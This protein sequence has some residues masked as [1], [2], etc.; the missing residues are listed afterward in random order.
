MLLGDRMRG[1]INSFDESIGYFV[2]R[3]VVV[4]SVLAIL[5][6]FY[7]RSQF[8][9]LRT[10]EAMEYAALARG[11]AEGRGFTTYCTRPADLWY[12]E[13]H[14]AR[15]D[16]GQAPPD[17]R[18]APL[19]PF[20]L[21]LGFRAARPSFEV[22]HRVAVFE[23]EQRVIVPLGVL[24]TLGTAGM[25]FLLGGRVADRR[26]TLAG[27]AVFLLSDAVLG[28]SIS[29]TPLPLVMFLATAAVYAAVVCVQKLL[30]ER[31]FLHWAVP[32]AISAALCALAFLSDYLM[33]ALAPAVALFVALGFARRPWSA[34][35]AFMLLVAIGV[36]P[37]LVRNERVSGGVLGIAPYAAVGHSALYADDS[38]DRELEPQIDN[39]RVSAALRSKITGNLGRLYDRDL[40]LLGSGLIMCFFLASFFQRF[41]YEAQGVLRWC[42]TL[43]IAILVAMLAVRGGD[44][45]WALNAFLPLVI[46]FGLASF[47]LI[48]DRVEFFEA[49]WDL[50]LTWVLVLLT[51][52]PA[53]LKVAGPRA[54]RPYPPYFP[55]F[56]SYVC[57][58]LRPDEALC[59]DIPWATAWYG[60]RRSVLLPR[61][62][63]D[64]YALHR[65]RL[66]MG[67]LYLTSETGDRP[68]TRDL[69]AGKDSAWLP[70]LNRSVPED[71]PFRHA[72]ALPPGSRDQ[73][74]LTDRVRW[75]EPDAP[76]PATPLHSE[77]DLEVTQEETS[78]PE[79]TRTNHG[80]ESA[81]EPGS[82]AIDGFEEQDDL[83]GAAPPG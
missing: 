80:G 57:E 4:V 77:E 52:L 63:E 36:A 21:S 48:L 79:G 76:A 73:L 23:P 2:L 54:A 37:W 49:G 46:L 22:K 83:T 56:V 82:T 10:P 78:A 29:G 17:I 25:L 3:A 40:R 18:H 35:L 53:A 45:A 74:F 67:G 55:P 65:S 42:V 69:V 61:R 33:I 13:K 30:D 58:L 27:V 14:A 59:T 75:A 41:E 31:P 5:F 26:A 11:L 43:G 12:L 72:I 8:R 6:A 7:A 1:A 20:L 71:F 60:N 19:Y 68:Y 15:K 50:V 16:P 81:T 62:M 9:G 44:A 28:G 38:F 39:V 34:G 24:F 70:V 51:A 66:P 64:F 47:F 32:F